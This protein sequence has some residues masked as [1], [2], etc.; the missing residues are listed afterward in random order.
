MRASSLGIRGFSVPRGA[1]A[2][3]VLF[4]AVVFAMHRFSFFFRR[5]SPADATVTAHWP[6]TSLDNESG[7]TSGSGDAHYTTGQ[8]H[9]YIYIAHQTWPW[10]F[11]C[12]AKDFCAS[13][14]GNSAQSS[15]SAC[16]S[17]TNVQNETIQRS[18]EKKLCFSK[19][20]GTG[21]VFR[22][23]MRCAENSILRRK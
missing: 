10:C 23:S 3:A 6:H 1:L 9:I 5:T 13:A 15:T 2:A 16:H 17:A 7:R 19:P 12:G 20:D 11:V 8:I 18:I 22:L 14:T 21:H 4:A